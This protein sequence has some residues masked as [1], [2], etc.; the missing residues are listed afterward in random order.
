MEWLFPAVT[1]TFIG[2]AI[3]WAVFLYL[4]ILDKTPYLRLWSLSWGIYA[5]RF[6]FML[7]YLKVEASSWF[8]VLNQACALWSAVFL[9]IGV[10]L[11]SEK[12][13][14]TAWFIGPACL[15]SVWIAASANTSL[16]FLAVSLPTFTLMGVIYVLTG[17][18][19]LRHTNSQPL[20]RH[21]TGWTFILWGLHKADYP[22]LRPA[23]WFAP[24][25]YI[26]GASLAFLTALSI[27]LLYFRSTRA[28]LS[29]TARRYRNLFENVN[30]AVYV[31]SLLPNGRVGR[32][33][34]VNQ[35]AVSMLGYSMEELKRMSPH[36]L[37]DPDMSPQIIPRA[38]DSLRR[39]GQARFEAV[40]VAKDGGRV[41]V[42]VN[43]VIVSNIGGGGTIIAVCRD[44]TERKRAE[45]RMQEAKSQ[46]EAANLAK[47]EFLANMSHEIRTP[48]NG[49]SGM[50]Q[51]LEGTALDAEQR[52]YVQAGL[53]S[54]QRL[55]S[56]LTD[57]LD[58]S[59]V[60]AGKLEIRE[61]P[62][63]LREILASIEDTFCRQ[64]DDRGLEYSWHVGQGV[65]AVLRGDSIRLTQVLF[66]LVGNAVKYTSDGWVSLEVLLKSE[67][68]SS[69]RL[70]F[71]VAD[72]GQGIPEAFQEQIFETFTQASDSE[73]CYA[74]RFEGAGLGL[75]LVK[76]LVNLMG[77]TVFLESQ[78]NQGTT[79]Y[80]LLDFRKSPA[81]SP[82]AIEADPVF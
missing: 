15:L 81:D 5:G 33:E 50:L 69:C 30:D 76:R 61:E 13:P 49:I 24:W 53:K 11:F 4:S 73:S 56:L 55:T 39:N 17:L 9:A 7:L 31:H 25:G 26:L 52:E 44:I 20:E 75:P 2:S 18:S 65:P 72:T 57:I 42:E 32:F 1:A 51:L 67:D 63:E 70:L 68:T 48:L 77:G 78:E 74:R 8:L 27:I 29:E 47:S 40:Q 38:V 66:N 36:E 3:L 34:Q 21:L 45:Q 79:I 64:I 23:D 62:F 22:F 10:R 71:T 19:F 37:D 80:V 82:E 46:A 43:A 14:K 58:L 12:D 54:S 16:S 28:E 41:Q 60:E 59:R 35:A 6:L